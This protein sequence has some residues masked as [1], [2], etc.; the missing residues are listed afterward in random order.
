MLNTF[1]SHALYPIFPTL[2]K[3]KKEQGDEE[4]LTKH[5]DSCML[6]LLGQDQGQFCPAVTALCDSCHRA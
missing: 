6:L 1:S 2:K 5:Q 3:K 4:G